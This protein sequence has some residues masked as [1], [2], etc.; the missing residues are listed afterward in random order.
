MNIVMAWHGAFMDANDNP[1]PADEKHI[2]W[3]QG[4]F[5]PHLQD[6]FVGVDKQHASIRRESPAP[7][8]SLDALPFRGR[9][10]DREGMRFPTG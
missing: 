4:V 2:Q 6:L 3:D 10:L 9:K 1:I 7:H 8:Q 5:H